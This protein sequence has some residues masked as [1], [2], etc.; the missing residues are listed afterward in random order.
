MK[1]FCGI[2]NQGFTRSNTLKEHYDTPKHLTN[3]AIYDGQLKVVYEKEK[4]EWE[5]QKAKLLFDNKSLREE[6][7]STGEVNF[8]HIAEVAVLKARLALYDGNTQIEYQSEYNKSQ[9][10]CREKDTVIERLTKERD[11]LQQELKREDREK[12][13]EIIERFNDRLKKYE[14]E[15]AMKEKEWKAE[16][17]QL[18]RKIKN[19]DSEMATIRDS[20]RQL[21]EQLDALLPE[22]LT[23]LENE[24]I[25]C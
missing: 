23:E 15:W 20:N 21:Q 13:K 12:G 25:D 6:L 8:K 9:K 22:R 7:T 24:I 10:V 5:I 17:S 3:Q 2:C 1:H 18:K 14:E 4:E 19:F 11:E 16:I